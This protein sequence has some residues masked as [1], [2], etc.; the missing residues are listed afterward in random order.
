MHIDVSVVREHAE[1]RVAAA[2]AAGGRMIRD[3][4]APQGWT[5]A[6]SAGNRVCVAA[7]PDGG[8]TE[9]TGPQ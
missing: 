8:F 4:D 7:W 5:L 1:A 9:R 6:D 3:G 2:Q